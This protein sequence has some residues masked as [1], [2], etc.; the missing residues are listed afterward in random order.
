MIPFLLFSTG[1]FFFFFLPHVCIVQESSK[2]LNAIYMQIFGFLTLWNLLFWNFT[3]QYPAALA[4]AKF[5]LLTLQ[6]SKTMLSEWILTAPYYIDG[7]LL[8]SENPESHL[9]S[10]LS[11]TG[12]YLSGVCLLLITRQC[13]EFITVTCKTF[14]LIHIT[15]PF[16]EPEP[17]VVSYLE[18]S[19]GHLIDL[20]LQ[21]LPLLS[22]FYPAV[23]SI[24]LLL[25]SYHFNFLVRIL[26]FSP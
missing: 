7:S 1:L 8:S 25:K 13:P 14:H 5:C 12:W 2:K 22:A 11:F 16:P 10:F 20:L 4:V 15:L 9:E 3:T 17:A 23:Q 18:C 24:L 26:Y 21:L 6:T 19:H